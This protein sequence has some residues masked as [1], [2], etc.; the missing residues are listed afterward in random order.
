M[1]RMSQQPVKIRWFSSQTFFSF[2]R[3]FSSSQPPFSHWHH[4]PSAFHSLSIAK[5]ATADY[6]W[7]YSLSFKSVREQPLVPTQLTKSKSTL[8]ELSKPNKPNKLDTTVVCSHKDCRMFCGRSTVMVLMLSSLIMSQRGSLRC[9]WVRAFTTTSTSRTVHR[10]MVASTL[11]QQKPQQ[12]QRSGNRLHKLSTHV[13]EDLDQALTSF[14]NDSKAA[15]NKKKIR[16]SSSEW[17]EATPTR[18]KA[19][20]LEPVSLSALIDETIVRPEKCFQRRT[21]EML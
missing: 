1:A 3:E 5:Q 17:A 13:E 19:S 14:L 11:G 9:G 21:G 18:E 12:Q 7:L 6:N 2:Q 15:S 4:W 8:S 16:V 20:K 10:A